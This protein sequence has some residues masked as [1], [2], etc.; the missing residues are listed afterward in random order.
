MEPSEKLKEIIQE[1]FDKLSRFVNEEKTDANLLIVPE[2][3]LN[4]IELTLSY[5]GKLFKSEDKSKDILTSVDNV[6]NKME[7]QIK[8]NKEKIIGKKK[9]A[10]K[11]F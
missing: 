1:K 7:R 11:T 3:H 4:K 8:R 5:Y 6:L 10:S 9:G 2:K